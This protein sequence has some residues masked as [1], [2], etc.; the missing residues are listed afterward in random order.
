[1]LK[2][3]ED[4][5]GIRFRFVGQLDGSGI[6]YYVLDFK[7]LD[8]AS[9]SYL[10]YASIFLYT[11]P[12]AGGSPFRGPP[13][14]EIRLKQCVGK[15]VLVEAELENPL[16]GVLKQRVVMNADVVRLHSIQLVE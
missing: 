15:K 13:E 10:E 2:S 7:D 14:S 1:M 6:S 4:F 16:G 11:G 8:D 3:S 9:K 5:K 12:N